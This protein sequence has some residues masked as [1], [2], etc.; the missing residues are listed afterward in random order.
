MS[1]TINT[2]RAIIYGAQGWVGYYINEHGGLEIVEPVDGGLTDEE[3]RE[4]EKEL[5]NK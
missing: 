2:E 5:G 4:A 1:I 3:F